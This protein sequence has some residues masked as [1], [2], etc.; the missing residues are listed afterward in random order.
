VRAGVGGDRRRRRL[1][2][3]TGRSVGLADDQS[4]VV[5][6]GPQRLQA[7]QREFGTSKKD[8][9]HGIGIIAPPVP[10]YHVG[11]KDLPPAVR[12]R[13]RLQ[14]RGAS[15]LS[16]AELLAIILRTGTPSCN[17]LELSTR[18]LARHAGL[19]GV[20]RAALDE[21]CE[22]PG[23][24]P[25]KAVTIKAALELGKRLV[26]LSPGM[27]VRIT[28]PRDVF[29]LL[30]AEMVGLEQ[31][32]LR[33]LQL[34]ARNQVLGAPELYRGS[35]VGTSVRLGELFR[36]A[37]RHNVASIVLVH[38]HP[39]GDPTPSAEDVRLTRDAVRAGK[40]LDIEVLDHLVLGRGEEGFVSM[41]ER[42]LG[43]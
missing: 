13:E 3:A 22:D 7:R 11:V 6:G 39:S 41:K 34:N 2:P 23:L 31:E 21:L 26:S 29:N 10:G 43:F 20:D 1:A 32:Q 28:S 17:A 15:D 8:Q 19:A 5:S 30:R 24:G 38:N 33:V 9:A 12:P 4:D 42:A 35:L 14:S 36:D 37:I 16:D 18:V 40:L 25:N 27:R